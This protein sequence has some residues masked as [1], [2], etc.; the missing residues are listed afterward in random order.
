MNS[1]IIENSKKSIYLHIGKNVILHSNNIIGIFDLEVI[2]HG[3]SDFLDNIEKEKIQNEEDIEKS[4][5]LI[6]KGAK[7]KGYI[8]NISSTTL[9]KRAINGGYNG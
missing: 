8:T 5:I 4:L 6:K 9:E 1:N 3:E 2:N 7:I